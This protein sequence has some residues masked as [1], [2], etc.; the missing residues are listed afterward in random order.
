MTKQKN[1]S[2]DVLDLVEISRAVG[3]DDRL[4]QAGGG[5]TSVKS[6]DARTMHIKASG[7]GLRDMSPDRGYVT[8][9][10]PPLMDLLADAQAARMPDSQ[11]EPYVLDV[12]YQAV[13]GGP[14]TQARPSCEATLHAMLKRYVVHIHPIAVNGIIC[15]RDSRDLCDQL[16]RRAGCTMAW[17]PYTNP[18][19]P[20]A[21]LCRDEIEK[22]KAANDGR[23]PDALFLENHG[24]FV[25]SDDKQRSV[26]LTRKIVDEADKLYHKAR[27]AVADDEKR[28]VSVSHDDL[29]ETV[30]AVRR[31]LLEAGAETRLVQIVRDDTVRDLLQR[32]DAA[33]ILRINNTPD[34]VVYCLAYPVILPASKPQAKAAR[35]VADFIAEHGQPPR[36]VLVPGHGFLVVGDSQKAL[37]TT[38]VV[39]AAQLEVVQRTLAF[40]GPKPFKKSQAD[41]INNW[42]VEAYRRQL[43]KLEA[44]QPGPLT[45]KVAIVTGAGSGIG[46]GLATGI[47]TAG[48]HVILADIDTDAAD[49]TAQLIAK[50]CG[51]ARATVVMADVTNEQSMADAFRAAIEKYGAVDIAIAA[52]GIAPAYPIQDFPLAAFA[53]TLDINLTG[54]FLLGREAARW[55]IKQQTGGS[56][57]FISSKTGLDASKNNTA[58]NVTKAGELHLMRGL[59]L[60][61]GQYGIRSNAICPGNVFEGSKIWNPTY[62]AQAAKKRG[63]KP[64]E[65]IPYYISLTSLKQEIKQDDIANAAIF[66]ASD[67]SRV[68]SGQSLVVDAGQVFVR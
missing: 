44:G 27:K 53:K 29:T 9:A 18:G 59:A 60:E 19:H 10:M 55:M 42:E 4:V 1:V 64:E 41:Y 6:A 22:F 61:L 40:G 21:L 65:V 51:A 17:I 13:T 54:Y 68:I 8:M 37:A 52:A 58:Y 43:A 57:I 35:A 33:S 34:A 7:T 2:T 25:S 30:L 67:N 15:S 23:I 47:A 20:L 62:I 49:E 36:T 3:A 16:A 48:A 63:L 45:G 46:R 39:Y 32:K 56:L 50:R 66:L 14:D 31:A 28:K 26:D 12:M 11:R 5:N 38:A 24:L